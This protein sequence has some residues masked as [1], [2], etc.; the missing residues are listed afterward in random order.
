MRAKLSNDTI[1]EIT[2]IFVTECIGD[3]HNPQHYPTKSS[4]GIE[5][6]CYMS[7]FEYDD[8]VRKYGN[9]FLYPLISEVYDYDM[10]KYTFN[11]AYN[12][13]KK[14]VE[15]AWKNGYV[16]LSDLSNGWEFDVE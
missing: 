14:R 7:P 8:A 9:E 12:D 2:E 10:E 15:F 13:A 1:I 16:D 4:V 6:V 5:I 11:E 3:S